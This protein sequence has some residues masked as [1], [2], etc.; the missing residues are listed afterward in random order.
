MRIAFLSAVY[1]PEREP[2][3]VMAAQLVDRWIQDGYRVDVYCPFPNRP[4]GLVRQGW[5]RAWRLADNSGNLRVVRCWHWLVGRERRIWNR[6]L[7]NFT[8]GWSAAAQALFD[9]KPD[10][11]VIST[12]PF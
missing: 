7:E 4:E 9:G 2:A 11:L 10:V 3:A 1:K 12:W 6:L 5:K 8:F